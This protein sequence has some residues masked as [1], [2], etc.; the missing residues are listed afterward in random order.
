MHPSPLESLLFKHTMITQ[1]VSEASID[2][3]AFAARTESCIWESHV[4]VQKLLFRVSNPVVQDSVVGLV[5]PLA[6]FHGASL[7]SELKEA[8]DDYVKNWK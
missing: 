7:D 1:T 3:P 6:H 2:L 8:T 5:D 4:K